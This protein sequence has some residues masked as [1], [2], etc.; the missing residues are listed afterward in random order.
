VTSTEVNFVKVNGREMAFIM[1]VVWTRPILENGSTINDMVRA[2]YA[3]RIKVTSTKD[4]GSA[5]KK[6]ARVRK[7]P[8][9]EST[10]VPG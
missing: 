8:Q 5:A 4:N 2:H 10:M 6:A 3:V 9:L 1:T 7:F